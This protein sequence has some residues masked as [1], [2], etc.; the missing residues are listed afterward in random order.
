METPD[1]NLTPKLV[2][3]ENEALYVKVL[4]T[5]GGKI[6]NLRSKSP[7]V[8]WLWTNPSLSLD[9][10]NLE[11]AFDDNFYGGIDELFPNDLATSVSGRD[12]LDHGE[13]WRRNWTV[14]NASDDAVTMALT[15]TTVP[16]RFV[17]EICLQDNQVIVRTEVENLSDE[18]V[19]YL[20]VG[21][22][23]FRIDANSELHIPR[24][25]AIVQDE[26]CGRVKAEQS[27]FTWPGTELGL[28]LGQIPAVND[29]LESYYITNVPEGRFL[30]HRK[31]YDATLEVS[32]PTK[33]FPHVW[34]FLP[35]GGWRGLTTA[36]VEVASGYP[37]DLAE[38]VRMGTDSTL[39]ARGRVEAELT[40]TITTT[41]DT[42]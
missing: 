17:R 32:F 41:N 18:D 35:L 33:V 34:L 20:W 21:H 5:V 31:N 6:A 26:Q 40:Y 12:L 15:L 2:E 1:S 38:A 29:A 23:A 28:N 39:V 37:T 8:E 19:P 36:L 42:R 9:D 24:G 16:V 10:V 4:P 22:P 11:G 7:E 14:V 27:P 13:L 25:K 3:L 30:V